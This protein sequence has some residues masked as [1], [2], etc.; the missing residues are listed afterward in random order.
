MI[1]PILEARTSR[2]GQLELDR[3]TRL[4][5]HDCGSR[6]H[7]TAAEEVADADFHD[8]AATQFPVDG[9]VEQC[10]VVKTP[11][12]VEP[13]SDGPDLLRLECALR[14]DQ[15]PRVPQPPLPIAS[16]NS[17][18]RSCPPPG[19]ISRGEG[20]PFTAGGGSSHKLRAMERV[21]GHR[22]AFRHQPT[23]G[24]PSAHSRVIPEADAP[25]DG[26][27]VLPHRRLK[28]RLTAVDVTG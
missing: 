16:S 21:V 3:P 6:P 2:L 24:R 7:L 22:S 5:L 26:D 11:F 1:Q 20:P 12:S 19:R 15:V 13:E 10:P 4:L 27:T 25:H 8:V 14:A 18:C 28:P 17:E 23:D 9:K